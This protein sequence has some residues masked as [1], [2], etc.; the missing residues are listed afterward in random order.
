[1]IDR[2]EPEDKQSGGTTTSWPF[3]EPGGRPAINLAEWQE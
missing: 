1:M 2:V 3:A